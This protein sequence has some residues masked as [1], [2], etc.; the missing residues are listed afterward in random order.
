M[1]KSISTAAFL[2]CAIA[3][4]ATAQTA[5]RF[6]HTDVGA[7]WAQGYKGQGATITTVDNF[8]A[9]SYRMPSRMTG[10]IVY[11]THGEQTSLESSLLAPSAQ[12]TRVDY[13]ANR[14]TRLQLG[15]GFNVINASYGVMAN[16]G[17]SSDSMR[18]VA[19]HGSI[20]DAAWNGT[21]VVSKAAGNA[22]VAVDKPDYR[23]QIDYVTAGMVGAP[24]AIIVGALD[25]N[26]STSRKANMA[27]YSNT[28]GTDPTIQ[29]QFLSVGVEGYQIGLQGTSFAAPIVSAYAAIVSSKFRGATPV[30]VT[31]QLLDTARTDTIANYNPAVHGRGEA[32]LSRA[33][34]PVSIR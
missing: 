15:S 34:A 26:G 12:V 29:R 7:A 2:L 23:G 14:N 21:A 20:I 1:F 30:Q 24:S 17:F 27:S 25:K 31:N 5:P 22:G 13:T 8:G 28:A 19:L 33:L 10:S 6:A 11:G 16:P 32:S 18:R 9:G 3:G 4:A